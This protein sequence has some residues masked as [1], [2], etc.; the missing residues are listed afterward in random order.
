MYLFG[1]IGSRDLE[2]WRKF[3]LAVGYLLHQLLLLQVE[4]AHQ[5]RIQIPSD[6]IDEGGVRQ[7]QFLHDKLFGTLLEILGRHSWISLELSLA[8]LHVGTS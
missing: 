7:F 5:I 1:I 2:C 3:V 8:P 4:Q 6:V